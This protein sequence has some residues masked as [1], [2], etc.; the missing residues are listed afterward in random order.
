MDWN[1]LVLIGAQCIVLI[2]LGVLVALGHDTVITD[3]LMVVSGSLAGTG[4]YSTVKAATK[5]V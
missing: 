2:T 4:V 1:R 5:T 3:G